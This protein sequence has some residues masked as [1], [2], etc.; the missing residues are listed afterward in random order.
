MV[1]LAD[2]TTSK[3]NG[4]SMVAVLRGARSIPLAMGSL[5]ELEMA[6]GSLTEL[7]MAMG[8]LTMVFFKKP[9]EWFGSVGRGCT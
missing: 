2:L 9:G 6:M 5:T 7:G 4:L 8:S 1:S 3:G